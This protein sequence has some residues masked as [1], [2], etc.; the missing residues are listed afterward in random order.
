MAL[1]D[2]SKLLAK[3]TLKIEKVELGNDEFVYVR[4]M[5][6]REKDRWEASL[7]KT[8]PDGK[9]GIKT[10]SNMNDFRAKLVVNTICDENGTL[11]LNYDDYALL[12]SNMSADTLDKLVK[13]SQG[14][15]AISE[16][17]KDEILKN[18]EGGQADSS[19]SDFAS[20]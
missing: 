16:E 1:L 4:Q 17:D 18:S 20:N 7:L 15:N 9:G 10:E 12:S 2:R 5:T 3:E 14:L 11:L 13:A 6:G 19:T 8:V